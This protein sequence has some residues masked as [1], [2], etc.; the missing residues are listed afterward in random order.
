MADLTTL[1]NLKAWLNLTA[2]GDDAVLGRL[3]TAASGF[4]ENWLGRPIGLTGHVETRDGTGGTTLVFAVTPTV[5]VTALTIDGNPVSPSPDGIA[6][7]Y[8]FSPS[9][10][11]VIGGGFRRGLGNVLVSYQAGYAAVP[12]EVEQAVIAL[13]ALRYRERERIGLVSKGLAGETTSFAQKD[14]PAD[15]ATALQRYR[16]VVPL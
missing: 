12:P 4:I 3:V 16:K 10:L 7:G 9:R 6:P 2:T 15:V 8:V 5:A 13:A 14:M 1:A 11:A